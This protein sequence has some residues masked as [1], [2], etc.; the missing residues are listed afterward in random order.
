[1]FVF[2][3]LEQKSADR[4]KRLKVP[5]QSVEDD[6]LTKNTEIGLLKKISPEPLKF[7]AF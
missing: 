3:S 7:L 6:G 5:T 1:L 2:L 4:T